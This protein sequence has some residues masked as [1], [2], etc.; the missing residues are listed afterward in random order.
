ME[1]DCSE[2]AE[3]AVPRSVAAERLNGDAG[4]PG[5]AERMRRRRRKVD[6]AP[7]HE[8]SAII[9]THENRAAG[10]RCDAHKCPERQGAMCCRH[11]ARI[12]SLTV[13]G[14]RPVAV[15]RRDSAFGPCRAGRE[16]KRERSDHTPH[17]ETGETGANGTKSP[18]SP[19]AS[20][21]S[22]SMPAMIAGTCWCKTHLLEAR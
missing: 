14:Q 20:S 11:R 4:Q 1:F 9:D 12:E 15:D 6:D 10:G 7:A 3:I 19:L 17:E 8:W 13:G 2:E 22:Q 5:K 16:P 18:K 21:G